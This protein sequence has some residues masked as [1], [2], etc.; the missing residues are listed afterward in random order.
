MSSVVVSKLLILLHI[1]ASFCL[2][3]LPLQSL[4]NVG[5][6]NMGKR[7]LDVGFASMKKF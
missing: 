7:A 6:G 2:L 4:K 1:N 3:T 5:G